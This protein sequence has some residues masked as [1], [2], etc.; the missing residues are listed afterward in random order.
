MPT[1]DIKKGPLYVDS[2]NNR[3]GIG[4]TSPSRTLTV[5][6]G[7][8]NTAFRL[9]STD[10]EV[11][12]QFYDG[13]DTSTITGGTYGL[14]FNPNTTVNEAM[15]ID[16]SGNL[17]V[18]KTSLG[19][20]GAGSGFGATGIN[21]MTADAAAT[22][23]LNRETSDGEIVSFRKDNT[24]V[25][26]IGAIGGDLGIGTGTAGL[27]FFDQESKVIPYNTSTQASDDNVID[28]GRNTNRFKDLYLSGGVYLAGTGSANKLDH[29]EEGT[30]DPTFLAVTGSFG[31]ITYDAFTKGAYTRIG[32]VVYITGTIRTDAIT[33]GTAGTGVAVSGLPFT[34][35]AND[36][37]TSRNMI[38][39]L[40]LT[41][42]TSFA[43]DSPNRAEFSS[44]QTTFILQKQSSI[45]SNIALLLPSDL[46]TGANN[47]RLAFSGFY[48][49]DA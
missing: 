43:N 27:R 38:S 45:A 29:Y 41:D 32:R 13:S 28:L 25:G 48:F 7:T 42:Q 40:A 22:L 17:L 44:N 14:I 35:A 36:P 5:N 18:G 6:S 12:M 49:T 47:N 3:V 26:S 24:V 10:A 9:E 31:S 15:R 21:Y 8:T 33:V 39:P 11:A 20:V 19:A 1:S 37:T 4:T 46:G 34:V 16:S 2:T 30:W 23:R